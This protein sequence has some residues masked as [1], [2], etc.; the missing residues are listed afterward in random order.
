M[1]A[2]ANF[3]LPAAASSSRS[4]TTDRDKAI[5]QLLEMGFTDV[6]RCGAAL[7]RY[8]GQLEEVIEFLAEE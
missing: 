3:S 2:A 8:S 5:V 7:E 1:D 4:G 6:E